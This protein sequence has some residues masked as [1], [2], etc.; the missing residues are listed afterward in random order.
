MERTGFKI[1][2]EYLR[3]CELT[4]VKECNDYENKFLNW[5]NSFQEDAADFNPSSV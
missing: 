4:A 3:K 2:V 5:V 1:D